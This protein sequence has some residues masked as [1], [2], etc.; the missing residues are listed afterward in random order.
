MKKR[1]PAVL[2]VNFGMIL[3]G[4][5]MMPFLHL[6]INNASV[7]TSY[8]NAGIGSVITMVLTIVMV[9][10]GILNLVLRKYSRYWRIAALG[11]IGVALVNI[12]F[13]GPYVVLTETHLFIFLILF[14]V[15][16]K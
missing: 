4:L 9:I 10:I 8:R 16:K 6:T 2:L 7:D 5:G 12:F 11:I 1:S 14:L 3:F 15:I 13:L